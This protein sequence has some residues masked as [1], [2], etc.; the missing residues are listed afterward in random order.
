MRASRAELAGEGEAQRVRPPAGDVLLVHR[1]PVRR[2]HHAGIRLPAGAV[3]VAHLDRT[4]EAAPLRPV[5]PGLDR[6][7]RIARLVAEQLAVVHALGADDLA[8]VEQAAGVEGVLDLLE[9]GGEPRAEHR[10]VELA[11]HDAVAVLAG[12]GAAVLAHHLEALLGDGPHAPRAVLGLQIDDRAHVQGA[13]RRVRVPGAAGAVT[14]EDGVETAGVLGQ[15]LEP[16]RAVL[17]ERDRLSVPLHRHHDVEAR[18]AHVP[19]RALEPGLHRLDHRAGK[20]EVRHQLDEA[21]EPGEE[22]GAVLA[23]ELHQQQRVG[24]AAHEPLDGGTERRDVARELD[25]GAVDELHRARAERHDVPRRGHRLVE[26]R[27]VTHPE[28]AV[29]RQR[30][31]VELDLGEES[32]RALGSHQQVGHVVAA[33]HA[34]GHAAGRASDH[35]AGGTAGHEGVDVVAADPPEQGGEAARD[36]VGLAGAQRAHAPDEIGVVFVAGEPR[37]IPGDLAE[38]HRVPVGENCADRVHVVHHVAV[39]DG[40][41]AAGVVAGHAA[42]G[43]AVGRRDVDGEEEALGLQPGIQPVEHD[44]GL[45]R[46]AARFLVEVDHA[47]EMPAGVD[48]HRLADGL[49]TLRRAGAAGEDRGAGFAADGDRVRDVLGAARRHH[50]DRL[51]LVDRRI[52]AVAAPARGVEPDLALD[53]APQAGGEAGVSRTQVRAMPHARRSATTATPRYG[54]VPAAL[55]EPGLTRGAP[56]RRPASPA[57]DRRTAR[58]GPPRRAMPH[59]QGTRG[60]PALHRARAARPQDGAP[61]RCRRASPRA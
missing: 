41:R 60:P 2:T 10:L 13:D 3:V 47:V 26:G 49:P 61:S 35:R 16:H 23:R 37:E 15:V 53:L 57:S 59:R 40:A 56:P 19:H 54:S 34:A 33:G 8:R 51:D 21:R 25:E 7:R 30:L 17:D 1:H 12:V 39:A 46:D 6:Q 9:R 42:D 22:G 20:A 32:E 55:A 28:H 5:E 29:G 4:V 48:D 44:A 31:Q 58:P 43:G 14:G 50:A 45:D 38:P 27:E 52:G 36:L 11:A 18:L 24:R